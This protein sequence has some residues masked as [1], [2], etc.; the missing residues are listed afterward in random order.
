MEKHSFLYAYL[1]P[2][3][4]KIDGDETGLASPAKRAKIEGEE[5]CK[6]AQFRSA[7]G[8]KGDLLKGPGFF[9]DDWRSSLCNCSSCRVQ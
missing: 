9:D 6:L 3:R 1:S 7:L 8:E 2:A 5:N 4:L